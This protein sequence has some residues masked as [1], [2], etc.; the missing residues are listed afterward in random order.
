MLWLVFWA[1][2]SA[3]CQC[4]DQ[5]VVFPPDGATDVPLN[6]NVWLQQR[7]Q[8]A[9]SPDLD[10]VLQ[11]QDD[12]A[13]VPVSV[14]HTAA[15]WRRLTPDEPLRPNTRY[16]V[17]DVVPRFPTY[18][19]TSTYT[20]PPTWTWGAFTTGDHADLTP[21]EP[22]ELSTCAELDGLSGLCSSTPGV[23][24]GYRGAG[25]DLYEV[26][27][28][29]PDHTETVWAP[30]RAYDWVEPPGDIWVGAWLC[31]AP[32]RTYEKGVPLI[33]TTTALDFAGNRSTPSV[34]TTEP[35]LQEVEVEMETDEQLGRSHGSG[36][37]CATV[38]APIAVRTLFAAAAR[39]RAH[40]VP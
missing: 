1:W 37:G 39:R 28:A 33:I 40:R 21:P 9:G 7:R 18:T 4:S 8:Y 10:V 32:Y 12:S 23:I 15:D 16:V 24:L 5:L 36:G 19:S 20:S 31:N 6:A 3:A 11:A 25:A 38:D 26:S 17:T 35:C 13:P 34:D 27:V 29:S 22:P 30:R 14:S 2:E